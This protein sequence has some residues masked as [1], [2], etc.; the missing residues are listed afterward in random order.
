MKGYFAWSLLDNFEWASGYTGRYGMVYIEYR[1]GN[2]TRYP[3]G[4]A[5]WYMNFLKD[6]DTDTLKKQIVVPSK[7]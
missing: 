4:S 5:I 3:K 1:D 2:L 6:K 7:K